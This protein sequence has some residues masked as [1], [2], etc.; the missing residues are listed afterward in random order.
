FLIIALITF[1]SLIYFSYQDSSGSIEYPS[2][3][4]IVNIDISSEITNY[5]QQCFIKF[6]PISFEF[7]GSNW[8]ERF[9]AANIR[10]RNSDGGFSFE[11]FQ[12]E[13]LFQM[14]EDDDW[15]LL[16]P[17]KNLDSL[18]T[19]MAFDIYNMLKENKSDYLLPL[20]TLVEV[21]INGNFQGIYLL[22]ERID[23]KKMNLEQENFVN[24]EENDMI[25]KITDWDGD[26]FTVYN[27]TN[28]PWEQ[29]HPNI[30]DFSQVPI[31]LTQLIQNTSEENFFNEG[32]GIFSIFD[33]SEIIDNLLFGLFTG[34]EIIEGSSYFLIYNR[35]NAAGFY[36]LPWN[37]AQSWGFSEDGSIPDDLWLN[38]NDNEIDSV[39]WSNLYYRLLFPRNS[40]INN[41]FMEEIKNRWSYIRSNLWKGFIIDDY[42]DNLYS[43]ILNT[44]FRTRISDVY[45]IKNTIK[46]WL[47]TRLI[48][49]DNIF[50]G[51]DPIFKDNFQPPFREDNEIFGF[52]S[53]AARRYYFKSS[54]LFS[55]NKIHDVSVV[56]Q[57]NYLLDIMV[58]KK[59]N[60]R[61]SDR[62]YMPADVSIDDYSMD[63]TGFRVR[64]TYNRLYPKDS[65]KLK[66][67]E[68]E[69]Y[70]GGGSFLNI[71]DN[72]G[73]RF[74]GLRR[75][76]LRAAPIDFSLMNEVAGY[77]LFRELGM[78]CPR[79]SWAR[80]YITETDENGNIIRPK[81]YKGLY[82]LTEDIDKTFLRYHFNNPEGNLYKTT[83]IKANL[84][85]IFMAW[86]GTQVYEI[87]NFMAFD[88]G[89]R[90]YELRTNEEQDDYSDLNKFI[91]YINNNWTYISEV[92]NLT[93]LANYFAASNFQGN[94]DDYIFLPHNYFMYSDP[95]YGFVFIPWD[96]EQNLNIGTEYS[97]IG[98]NDPYSPDFRYAPLHLGYKGY[99]DG[100]SS[101]FGID[102]D[103]RPLWDNLLNDSLFTVKYND[104]LKKL[105]TDISS[106]ISQ[107]GLWFNFIEPTAITPFQFTD[108]FPDPS[109]SW[110]YPPVIDYGWFNFVAKP[111]V[112][113]FLTVRA[114][115]VLSQLP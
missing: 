56:I 76:N 112:L 109:V 8:A 17:G 82:L 29:L 48:L 103:N 50:N 46:S 67:S 45:D 47:V 51:Q 81:E 105:A 71:P 101:S 114:T 9:L 64:G 91:Q 75:L 104:S 68:T 94:W 87:K 65:F 22:S 73:R 106:L 53:P 16:P 86:N 18:R 12:R 30:V 27:S 58:R 20:S 66:F 92:A 88:E 102:P 62:V 77:E 84:D 1:S 108:P 13:K 95:N 100:I 111:R 54:E 85:D 74:L 59:N 28:S 72:E 52:S 63:N 11:L 70:L 24:Q 93:L 78:P 7:M 44:L 90:V 36:S 35:K 57:S 34:H 15:L 99:F 97:I 19:K 110:W 5:S 98:Y 31:N 42:L 40:S 4:P 49:L 21:H 96:I 23:R 61:Q 38:E 10:K 113:D 26:F 3:I 41:E 60:S 32:N 89:T 69:F 33:K 43:S 107:L 83:D 2:G 115:Y 37:F 39:C 25:F 79:I 80:L 6:S 55:R 14:R